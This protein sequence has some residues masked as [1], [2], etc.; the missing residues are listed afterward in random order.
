MGGVD[1][2]L[3]KA[4][5]G[6]SPA[7]LDVVAFWG[8]IELKVPAGWNV[9]GQVMPILGGFEDKTQPLVESSRGPSPRRAWIRDHGRRGDRQLTCP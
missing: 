5:M 6:P 8:G 4:R 7:V 3:R 1:L 9:E 2:D